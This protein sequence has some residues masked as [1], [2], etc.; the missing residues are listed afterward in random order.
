MR[1]PLIEAALG[2][3]ASSSNMTRK[4]RKNTYVLQAVLTQSSEKNAVRVCDVIQS[5]FSYVFDPYLG[6]GNRDFAV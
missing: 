4:K 5:E 6:S 3:R 1:K 2:G